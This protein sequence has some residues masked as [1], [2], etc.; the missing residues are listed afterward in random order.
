MRSH[1]EVT[2]G[3]SATYEFEE[4]HNLMRTPSLMKT[5]ISLGLECGVTRTWRVLFQEASLILTWSLGTGTGSG[6]LRDC[7]NSSNEGKK[8]RG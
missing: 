6:G 7:R 1:F 4:G 8:K 2:E 3:R 5:V